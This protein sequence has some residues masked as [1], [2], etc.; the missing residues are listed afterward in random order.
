[1]ENPQNRFLI[2][3]HN[4][5]RKIP[6]FNVKLS[7]F[8]EPKDYLGVGKVSKPVF[9]ILYFPIATKLFFFEMA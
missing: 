8:E 3:H 6:F 4:K 5:R 1:M 7:I 9:P 2:P